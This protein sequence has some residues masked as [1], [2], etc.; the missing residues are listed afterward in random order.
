[1]PFRISNFLFGSAALLLF[2]P[3]S[4]YA[5][6]DEIVVSARK[7]DERL[8]DVP[9][10]V[11]AF[12]ERLIQE[13]RIENLDDVA[14]FTPGLN[15]FSPVGNS[16][17]V[18]VIRGVAPT[19]IFGETNAAVFID[20]VYA[21]GREGLNFALLDVQRI[22]VVKGPQSALYGRNAFSG[23]LN[24][25]TKRPTNEFSSRV[26]TT[27]GNRGRAK[28]KGNISGPLIENFLHA[29]L[30]LGYD[31]WDGSYDN[32]IADSDVGGYR[33]KT[34]ILGVDFMPSDNLTVQFNAYLSDD[35]IDE[36]PITAQPANCENVGS[37]AGA[38]S[39]LANL[40]GDVWDL[41]Q[42]RRAYN[43]GILGNPNVPT[44]LQ[45]RT[46]REE[47]ARIP[48]ALGEDRQVARSSL[49]FDW[50]IGAGNIT[51]TTGYSKV[52][53]KTTVDG[54]EGLGYTQP[55]AY[56]TNVIGYF[57]PGS[58]VPI[59]LDNLSG[60]GPASRFTTGLLVASPGDTT[61]EISQELR[62]A[63]PQDQSVRYS[64]GTYVYK[65]T[66]HGVG[67]TLLGVAPSLPAGLESMTGPGT[68]PPGAAFGPWL[69]LTNAIG[70]PAFREVFSPTATVAEDS[71][72]FDKTRAYAA[73]ATLDID[74]N[75]QLTADFQARFT[76]ET[77]SIDSTLGVGQQTKASK[78]FDS[79]TGR[80]G[81][82]WAFNDDSM[83]YGSISTG[84]K[85][86]GFDVEQVDVISGM[87]GL[88]ENRIVVIPFEKETILAYELGY[89]G[90]MLDGRARV[91]LSLYR[92]DWDDI[93][94]P[95][96]FE[97]E[98]NTGED[99]EQPEGFNTNAGDATV[100]GLEVQG[101]FSF[102]DNWSGG[103]GLSFT[104]A[105]MD[106]AKLESFADFPSFAPDGDVSGN[107]VLRQP[108]K[109]AN[110]NIRYE[111]GFG[112][113]WL[114]SARTDILY[115]GKYYGGLDNQ[116]TIPSRTTVNGRLGIESDTWTISLW[117]KNLLNDNTP[118]S[119]YRNVYFGNTDDIFQAMPVNSTPNK[120]FPWR[121]SA[122]H[123]NL[124][125]FGITLEVR[126]GN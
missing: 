113:D 35:A 6:V 59:C 24:Y 125:T 55:F 39:R 65:S 93:V 21:A 15:F 81:L 115:Q 57:D 105:T 49:K 26:E 56:C 22:E 2:A 31:T 110:A 38:N 25:V 42:A 52:S 77:K 88:S 5:A 89:K 60:F 54:T 99:L 92:M 43:E 101:D 7:I 48:E 67:A 97:K 46:G 117:V 107:D 86:G 76:S 12:G 10:A 79:T 83:I 111:R 50:D 16:L 90:S 40:C 75:D 34:A 122:T 102:T 103:I 64:V 9:I 120:F 82:K 36:A 121:I 72:I 13:A 95:Q 62:F 70:D 73:F 106:T 41:D 80:A 126:F 100:N 23:A 29:G 94:I 118:I 109:Q 14:S 44:A 33:Y 68:L 53:Y 96:I 11:T 84:A 47:I 87:T 45:F 8:Q 66:L 28:L 58:T 91:D 3:V 20:G 1:M 30:T 104:D 123:P 61:T 119:G 85:P 74:I 27:A 4:G 69:N 63:S 17:P 108:K 98:P 124:R 116:W 112:S 37:D 51:A 71:F 78:T 114:F 18:P 19:D 32:P